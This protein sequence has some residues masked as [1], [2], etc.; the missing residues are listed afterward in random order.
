MDMDSNPY[1]LAYPAASPLTFSLLSE[2]EEGKSTLSKREQANV[3]ERL[4][5]SFYN[6]GD[7]G[8]AVEYLLM[9]CET[10]EFY[11][12]WKA[13]GR[14]RNKLGCTYFEMREY[15]KSGMAFEG[16][17]DD[18]AKN[19][20]SV[21]IASSL[22]STS[23]LKCVTGDYEGAC[24]TIDEAVA[25][26]EAGDKEEIGRAGVVTFCWHVKGV[27]AAAGGQWKD[28]IQLHG[29]DLKGG[30]AA[31]DVN[32][33]YR[34][35]VNLGVCHLKNGD[36]GEGLALFSICKDIG[37]GDLTSLEQAQAQEAAGEMNR[38]SHLVHKCVWPLCSH[39]VRSH[40]VRTHCFARRYR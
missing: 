14:L 22:C 15:A 17:K 29:K 12:D 34:A 5:D 39:R 18:G 23:I 3:C 24:A 19:G 40:R 36:V 1:A 30:E 11:R 2:H 20:K 31:S 38:D 32:A 37:N 13:C 4:A 8:G 7:R 9:A 28:A 33:V 21:V 10:F 6:D 27:V 16:Q 35:R 25:V 26:L